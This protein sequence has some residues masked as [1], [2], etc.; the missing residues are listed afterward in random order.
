MLHKWR[1][2]SFVAEK[3]LYSQDMQL[4]LLLWEFIF[5]TD[6]VSLIIRL[7]CHNSNS[8]QLADFIYVCELLIDAIS[9]FVVIC[10]QI[11]V[12]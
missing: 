5:V 7:V 11:F 4:V 8:Y 12:T 6:N 3:V 2:V 1:G 10:C 9:A